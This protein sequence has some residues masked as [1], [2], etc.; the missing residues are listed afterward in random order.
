MGMLP[1]T[2]RALIR[3]AELAPKLTRELERLNDNLEKL[4]HRRR[5]DSPPRGS[6]EHIKVEPVIK[7]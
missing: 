6:I 2:E 3:L 5:E 7:T 1:G 4:E